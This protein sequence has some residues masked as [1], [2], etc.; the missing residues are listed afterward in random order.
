MFEASAYVRDCAGTPTIVRA[1][2]I[3]LSFLEFLKDVRSAGPSKGDANLC[4][5]VPQAV[6]DQWLREG[7]DIYREDAKAI[8]ARLRAQGLDAFITS[9]V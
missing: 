7:F 3:P 6:V 9:K 5:S 1:Q 4:A 8:V 2:E